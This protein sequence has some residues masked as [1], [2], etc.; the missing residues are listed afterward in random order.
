MLMEDFGIAS[1]LVVPRGN[2]HALTVGDQRT[3]KDKQVMVRVRRL[4]NSG[5]EATEPF[6]GP[7]EQR[8]E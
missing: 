3:N 1:T 4:E 5:H 7:A 6:Q 8:D 2:A